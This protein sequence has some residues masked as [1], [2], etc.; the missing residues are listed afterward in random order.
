MRIAFDAKRMFQNATGLG[1]YSRTLVSNLKHFY[2]ENDYLLFSPK[3][4]QSFFP[5]SNSTFQVFNNKLIPSALWRSYWIKNDLKKAKVELYHGLSNEIP[6]DLKG[7]KSLV[8][9]HD[10]I[11]KALPNTYPH[12]DRLIYDQ[13]ARYACKN[14]RGII[15]ISEHT[16]KDIIKYYGIPSDK[17][18][19]IYQACDP[20]FYSSQTKQSIPDG[21]KN[22]PK[23]Y[24]LSIGSIIERKNLLHS[25][26][27]IQ[28]LPKDLRIPL[29]VVGKGKHYKRKIQE[30][31]RQ[32]RIEKTIIW[33][34]NINSKTHL[35]YL[36]QNAQALLYLSLYE[37]FGLPVAE[38]L[39]CQTP[40][41]TSERTALPEAGGPYSKLVNPKDIEATANAISQVL[42]DTQ[43]RAKM[44]KK[45]FDYAH[46]TFN[47][48]KL[49][50]QMMNFYKLI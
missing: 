37:G 30:Y 23:K 44:I 25:I 41:I 16:K 39:L 9:I 34:E 2:P 28:N 29:I 15:A 32:N 45:G 8:T 14:A 7:L 36:Y 19:V 47:P 13:K 33:L 46:K 18:Q 22:L 42:T 43:L 40:V 17:I 3:A 49:S 10:L 20:I 50:E 6:F 27:S 21:L 11:F 48:K 12:L 1:N 35:K 4:E 38:A 26:Q 24:L 5:L 31:L